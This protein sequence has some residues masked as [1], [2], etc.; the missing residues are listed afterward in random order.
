LGLDAGTA[1]TARRPFKPWQQQQQQQ[2]HHHHHIPIKP[3]AD[4]QT[5]LLLQAV[6]TV[7]DALHEA[8]AIGSPTQQG[9]AALLAPCLTF[10]ATSMAASSGKHHSCSCL[11]QCH[12][13]KLALLFCGAVDSSPWY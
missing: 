4:A 3:E 13:S 11:R 2:Q 7:Q 5:Q 6:S 10:L 12:V 9:M 8:A 1:I